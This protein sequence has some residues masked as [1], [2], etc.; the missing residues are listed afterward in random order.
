MTADILHRLGAHD[1]LDSARKVCT[2]WRN[3]CKDPSMWRVIDMKNLGKYHDMSDYLETICR[4]AV[5]RREDQLTDIH[6]DYF[7]TD[8]LLQYISEQYS[9]ISN[10][11]SQKVVITLKGKNAKHY[12]KYNK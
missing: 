2:T 4:H 9:F 7:A 12:Q 3:V 6:I 1:I 11:M 10:F 5:D 8:E